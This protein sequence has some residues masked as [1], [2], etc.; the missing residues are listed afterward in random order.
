MRQQGRLAE[1][2]L[3]RFLAGDPPLEARRRAE[4]L[5]ALLPEGPLGRTEEERRWDRALLVLERLDTPRARQLLRSLAAGDEGAWL[6]QEAKK[7]L[8]RL[9]RRSPAAP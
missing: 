9:T 4:A 7:T 5:L 1:S 3:K 8:E 2:R 6:T